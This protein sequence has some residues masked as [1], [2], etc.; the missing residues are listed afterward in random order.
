MQ[1][2]LTAC[3]CLNAIKAP[4]LALRRAYSSSRDTFWRASSMKTRPFPAGGALTTF[5]CQ[6]TCHIGAKIG[7]W[8]C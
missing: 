1:P 7:N 5:T 2:Q 4:F 3:L 8:E 6:S